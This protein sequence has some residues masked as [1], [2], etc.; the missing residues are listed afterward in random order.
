MGSV[1]RCVIQVQRDKTLRSTE[2]LDP[3][4]WDSSPGPSEY[5]SDT[6]TTEP[7]DIVTEGP[8]FESQLA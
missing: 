4:V 8:W 1:N 3:V 5:P 2:N 7:L 6:L